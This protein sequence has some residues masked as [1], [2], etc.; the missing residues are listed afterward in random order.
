VLHLLEARRRLRRA[1]PG[2]LDV[3]I[4]EVEK[5]HIAEADL[6]AGAV[7]VAEPEEEALEGLQRRSER[8]PIGELDRPLAALG[9]KA[10]LERFGV[11]RPKLPEVSSGGEALIFGERAKRL[12]NGRLGQPLASRICRI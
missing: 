4:R 11:A 2:D 12:V 1:I 7:L 6:G 3:A 9:E 5:F 8:R 10:L